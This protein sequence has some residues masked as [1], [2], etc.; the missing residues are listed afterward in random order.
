[1][2]EFPHHYRVSAAGATAGTVRV[3]A[4]ELPALDTMP[5]PQYGGEPGHWSPETLLVAAVADCFVLAFRSVAQASRL[6]W[7]SV[8]CDVEGTLERMDRV[9]LF[10]HFEINAELRIGDSSSRGKAERCLEKA[11]RAC[12]ITNSLKAETTLQL[13]IEISE[14][15]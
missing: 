3:S 12:L 8:R 10:T 13:Q 15:G 6:E 7:E 1:M 9:T 11:E 5:P 2:Q 14:S 4:A